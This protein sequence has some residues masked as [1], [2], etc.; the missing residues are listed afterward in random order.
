MYI[1]IG[2]MR[3][4]FL[5]S[6]L[7]DLP[8]YLLIA[9]ENYIKK[10]G[11][12]KSLYHM[13]PSQGATVYDLVNCGPRTRFTVINDMIV[14]NCVQST[15]HDVTMRYIYILQQE[16]EKLRIPMRPWMVDEHDA[17]V[18]EVPDRYVPQTIEVFNKA[19]DTLNDTLGWGIKFKG[20]VKTG[21]SLAIKCD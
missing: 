21:K 2:I 15:A 14:S 16:R 6:L 5:R 20:S 7:E 11:L 9:L 8:S 13:N 1:L 3:Q 10:V 17:T 19:M 4:W 18:W 12:Q